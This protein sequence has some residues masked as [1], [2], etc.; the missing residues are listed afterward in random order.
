MVIPRRKTFIFNFL[1]YT[2]IVI[3]EEN[4]FNSLLQNLDFIAQFVKVSTLNV[5]GLLLD[6]EEIS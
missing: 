3:V 2:S 1:P 5:S 4:A 6:G